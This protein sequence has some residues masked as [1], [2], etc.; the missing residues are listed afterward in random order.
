MYYVCITTLFINKIVVRK[1][2]L[3]SCSLEQFSINPPEQ[4]E[5]RWYF[6]C[7]IFTMEKSLRWNQKQNH[8]EKHPTNHN[9]KE[10]I[11]LCERLNFMFR[12]KSTKLIKI[13]WSEDQ[14]KLGL[15]RRRV[16]QRHRGRHR[17]QHRRSLKPINHHKE[18]WL[19]GVRGQP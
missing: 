12:N 17:H 2:N 18:M 6:N 11:F 19:T 7:R 16:R 5:I 13:A 14:K 1:K 4:I 8:E 10:K 3:E 15:T 9:K